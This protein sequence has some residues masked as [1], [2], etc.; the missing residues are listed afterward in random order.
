MAM[1][2]N[3]SD[4]RLDRKLFSF[5]FFPTYSNNRGWAFSLIPREVFWE[6]ESRRKREEP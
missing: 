4:Y 6:P 2:E 3:V 5:W 1:K